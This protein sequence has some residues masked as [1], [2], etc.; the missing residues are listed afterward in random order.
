M[1]WDK[2]RMENISSCYEMFVK[3]LEITSKTDCVAGTEPK[4]G[5]KQCGMGL[6]WCSVGNPGRL[7]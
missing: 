7:L 3:R 5:L 2:A 4:M 6:F 1:A